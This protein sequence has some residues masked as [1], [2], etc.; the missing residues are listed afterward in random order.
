M[1]GGYLRVDTGGRL[2]MAAYWWVNYGCV[3]GGRLMVGCNC[4]GITG[5]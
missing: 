2:L 1:V 3:T 4:W 5:G